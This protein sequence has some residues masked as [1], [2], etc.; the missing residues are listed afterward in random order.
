M[1]PAVLQLILNSVLTLVSDAPQ[2]AAHWSGKG[3]TA[4]AFAIVQDA[5]GVGA[6]VVAHLTPEMLGASH[7]IAGAPSAHV[8]ASIAAGVD[9]VTGAPV[10][11]QKPVEI[12]AGAD[13]IDYDKLAAAMLRAQKAA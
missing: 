12:R 1:N 4:K 8:A 2:L 10:V 9:P 6:D 7:D 13:S 11:Q 5:A 3:S